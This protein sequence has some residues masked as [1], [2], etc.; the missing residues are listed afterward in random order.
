MVKKEKSRIPYPLFPI[1]Y[2]QLSQSVHRL[3]RMAD[4]LSFNQMSSSTLNVWVPISVPP[5]LTATL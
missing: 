1:P 4:Y 3:S 5:T 2:S